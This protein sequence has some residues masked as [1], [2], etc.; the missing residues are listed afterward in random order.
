MAKK[1][2]IKD[3]NEL[4]KGYEGFIKGKEVRKNGKELFEKV[5]KAFAK[6]KPKPKDKPKDSPT[7]E[8]K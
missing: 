5:V 4:T 2:I 6:G 3:I 1:K 7:K 8:S